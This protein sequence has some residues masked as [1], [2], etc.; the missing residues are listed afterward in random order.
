MKLMF[1][2]YRNTGISAVFFGVARWAWT[3]SGPV[4]IWFTYASVVLAAGMGFFLV[5]INEAHFRTRE[6][7]FRLNSWFAVTLAGV[8][9]GT[10][11]MVLAYLLRGVK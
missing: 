4:P 8:R 9:I 5:A 6:R 10:W 7:E 2:Y 11:G 3:R 1:D